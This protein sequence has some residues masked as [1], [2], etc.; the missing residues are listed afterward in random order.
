MLV[1]EFGIVG[2]EW[3]EKEFDWMSGVGSFYE[4]FGCVGK[5]EERTEYVGWGMYCW[6]GG[7]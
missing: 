5:E 6:K 7:L 4:M 1:V 3:K 2:E